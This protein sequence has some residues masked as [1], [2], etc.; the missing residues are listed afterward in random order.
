M[1]LA[2]ARE[3]WPKAAETLTFLRHHSSRGTSS[4]RADNRCQSTPAINHS[5]HCGGYAV[6]SAFERLIEMAKRLER[7]RNLPRPE[8]ER[9]RVVRKCLEKEREMER[10]VTANR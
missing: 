4:M 1:Y 7:M 3:K 9:I 8:R 6:D 5:K 10:C 2:R